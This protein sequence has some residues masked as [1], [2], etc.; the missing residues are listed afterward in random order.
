MVTS[1]TARDAAAPSVTALLTSDAGNDTAAFANA[2]VASPSSIV[3]QC[4][5]HSSKASTTILVSGGSGVTLDQPVVN[6]P[7]TNSSEPWLTAVM[8]PG[9]LGTDVML[10][11]LRTKIHLDTPKGTYSGTITF[12]ARGNLST[13]VNA[14]LYLG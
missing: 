8:N 7:L 14:T 11:T 1:L 5:T 4:K 6:A 9:T 10:V 12:T 13:T 3:L 2:I